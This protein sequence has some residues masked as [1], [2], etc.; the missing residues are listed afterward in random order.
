MQFTYVFSENENKK[1][2]IATYFDQNIT[3][4]QTMKVQNEDLSRFELIFNY[5]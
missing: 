1:N 3:R 5:I 4:F 2:I